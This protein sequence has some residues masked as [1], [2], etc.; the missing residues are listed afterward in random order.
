MQYQDPRSRIL[1]PGTR[2]Q[3]PGSWVIGSRLSYVLSKWLK[4]LCPS[5][6]LAMLDDY[7]EDRLLLHWFALVKEGLPAVKVVFIFFIVFPG[8]GTYLI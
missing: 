4:T 5:V 3:D 2:S 6:V 1:D 7:M 8:P